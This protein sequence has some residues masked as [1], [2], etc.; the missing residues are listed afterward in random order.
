MVLHP[1][2][3]GLGKAIHQKIIEKAFGELGFITLTVLFPPSRSCIKGL[4]RL[5]FIPDGEVVIE[6]QLFLRH[7]I[8]KACEK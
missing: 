3:W 2:Y 8:S 4:L 5:G 6:G 1:K 7:R